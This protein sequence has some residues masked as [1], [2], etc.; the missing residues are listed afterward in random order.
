MHSRECAWVRANA[1]ESIA[2][3]TAVA[4]SKERN[5]KTLSTQACSAEVCKARSR[6]AA[7]QG[8]VDSES[9][10]EK[11]AKSPEGQAGGGSCPREDW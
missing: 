1:I 3:T 7:N 10:G 11:G 2:T 5:A 4:V 8:I 6:Q 9:I